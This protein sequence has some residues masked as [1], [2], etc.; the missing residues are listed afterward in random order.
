MAVIEEVKAKKGTSGTLA[1]TDDAEA[2]DLSSIAAAVEASPQQAQ[3]ADLNAVIEALAENIPSPSVPPLKK[4][5]AEVAAA[6]KM[7]I[8]EERL[9]RERQQLAEEQRKFEEEKRKLLELQQKEVDTQSESVAATAAAAAAV[10]AD[11]EAKAV[12][13]AKLAAEAEAAEEGAARA[14]AEAEAAAEARRAEEAQREAEQER[15]AEERARA[16]AEEAAELEEEQRIARLLEEQREKERARKATQE[17]ARELEQAQALESQLAA[18][19]PLTHTS[20]TLPVAEEVT[21]TNAPMVV[22][23]PASRRESLAE[24]D[25]VMSVAD[26]ID[27]AQDRSPPEELDE[28]AKQHLLD[29]IIETTPA[30]VYSPSHS[31]GLSVGTNY[32]SSGSAEELNDQDIEAIM[33][34]IEATA[35]VDE[36]DID[37]LIAETVVTVPGDRRD[38]FSLAVAADPTP[39]LQT[40]PT[41]QEVHIVDALPEASGPPQPEL[42]SGG[43]PFVRQGRMVRTEEGEMALDLTDAY[44]DVCLSPPIL[45]L[46]RY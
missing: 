17:E 43:G 11:A 6:N 23:A 26:L 40:S 20:Q 13:E 4:T 22:T 33:N 45:A 38:Y 15:L 41:T 16:E 2:V 10:V 18:E 37:R 7:R 46:V 36:I 39:L 35:Y 8:E 28:E 31:R 24:S 42:E 9:E 1:S 30:T 12:E 5:E 27:N 25:S 3:D 29:R 14:A 19:T 34:S 44:T 21:S 32:Q